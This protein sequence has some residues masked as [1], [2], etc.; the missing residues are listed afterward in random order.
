MKM[1]QKVNQKRLKNKSLKELEKLKWDIFD[2]QI[3]QENQGRFFKIIL[4]VYRKN[5]TKIDK[6]EIELAEMY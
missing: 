5:L 6:V 1:Y 2:K 3:I 4:I